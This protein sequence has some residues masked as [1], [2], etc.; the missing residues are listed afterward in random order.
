MTKSACEFGILHFSRLVS[1]F[2]RKSEASKVL[3]SVV[4]YLKNLLNGKF[5]RCKWHVFKTIK[6]VAL[7]SSIF[8]QIGSYLQLSLQTSM[9]QYVVFV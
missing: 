9:C 8:F 1:A 4:N 7:G 5:V 3:M 6:T 2:K